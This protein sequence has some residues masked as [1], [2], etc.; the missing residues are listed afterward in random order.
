MCTTNT[1]QTGMIVRVDDLIT[2]EA[3]EN[4]SIK[5]RVSFARNDVSEVIHYKGAGPE[6]HEDMFYQYDDYE[7]FLSKYQK[8]EFRKKVWGYIPVKGAK[9]LFKRSGKE[10]QRQ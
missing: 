9:K 10:S 6:H 8:R 5:K 1:S 2:A 7:K 3:P 4:P